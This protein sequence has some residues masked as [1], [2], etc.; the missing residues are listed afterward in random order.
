MRGRGKEIDA[1]LLMVGQI[2]PQRVRVHQ[3]ATTLPILCRGLGVEDQG[4]GVRTCE[5]AISP[6]GKR[7]SADGIGEGKLV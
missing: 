4:I 6:A 7:I 5:D 1:G 3:R 2:M